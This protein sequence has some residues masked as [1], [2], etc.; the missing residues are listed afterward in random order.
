MLLSTHQNSLYRNS[1]A[2]SSQTLTIAL[3]VDALG[4][5]DEDLQYIFLEIFGHDI[6]EELNGKIPSTLVEVG[7][8]V[9]HF[10]KTPSPVP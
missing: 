8:G 4:P 2:H 7:K 5:P 6:E 3:S 10:K 9:A 1:C